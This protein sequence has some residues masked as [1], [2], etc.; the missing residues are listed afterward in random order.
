MQFIIIGLGN[1]G[2]WL[3]D[4]LTQAG[5]EVIGIDNK[6]ER[7]EAY[8]DKLTHVIKL[9]STDLH[10]LKTLPL[11]DVDAVIVAIGEDIGASLLTTALLKQLK[12]NRI[13]GR[14]ISPVHETVITAIGIDEVV[15]P[16]QETAERWSKKLDMQGVVESFNISGDYNIIE[17]KTPPRYADK[18][19]E[20]CEIREKY[21]LN[22]IT[23]LRSESKESIFGFEKTVKNSIGVVRADTIIMGDDLLVMF[24]HIKDIKRFI[25]DHS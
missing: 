5:H 19:I 9:D 16:E 23:I 22:V 13:I 8:K 6:M 2:A 14:V 3:G 11:K 4:K 1:F 25:E 15:H 12:V 18:T 7:V 20:K 10:A 21:D 17:V 24:G